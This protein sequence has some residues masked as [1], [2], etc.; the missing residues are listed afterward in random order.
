MVPALLDPI[1]EWGHVE[2]RNS[3]SSNGIVAL[4]LLSACGSPD[5]TM[6]PATPSTPAQR[7]VYSSL[8]Q[9]R[10]VPRRI[11]EEFRRISREAPG[12]TGVFLDDR[13]ALTISAARDD[14]ST[15]SVNLV[16][17]WVQQYAGVGLGQGTPTIRRVKYDYTTLADKYDVMHNAIAD[18]GNLLSTAIDE[19]RGLIVLGVRSA[20]RV[21]AFKER[22]L[23]RGIPAD[24]IEFEERVPAIPSQT[25]NSRFRPLLGGLEIWEFSGSVCTLGFNVMRWDTGYD[26]YTSPHYMLTAGHCSQD[27]GVANGNA[28]WQK[29]FQAVNVIGTTLQVVPKRVAPNCPTGKS[30]CIDADVLAV[31]YNS[32]VT[33][34]DSVRYGRV[35]NVNASKTIITPYYSVQASVVGAVNGQTITMVGQVSGKRT[36]VVSRICEDQLTTNPTS[37]GGTIWVLCQDRANYAS[38]NGDS[39]AP[40]FIPYNPSNPLTPAVVGLHSS[41]SSDGYSWFSSYSAIDYALGSAYFIW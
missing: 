16:T 27:W 39:G 4:F 9:G 21:D 13:G 7:N 12:F 22:L 14:F 18:D 17:S 5:D 40:L 2:M 10:S 24:M 34:P 19:T 25:L 23:A 15:A 33:F 38:A 32:Y 28:Y 30:P 26:P 11:P 6:A 35:A 29:G 36:D 41:R 37:S 31:A 1:L 3:L 20:D 8:M